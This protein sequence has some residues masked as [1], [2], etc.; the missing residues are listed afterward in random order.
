MLNRI[1]NAVL[2]SGLS[3]KFPV[4]ADFDTRANALI[5]AFNKALKGKVSGKSLENVI[6]ASGIDESYAEELFD[7]AI[8]PPLKQLIEH[9]VM[10]LAITGGTAVMGNF[11]P[12]EIENT[13]AYMKNI[14]NL[15]GAGILDH[16]FVDQLPLDRVKT[17]Y[18]R[19]I[20][21]AKLQRS[22]LLDTGCSKL[23]KPEKVSHLVTDVNNNFYTTNTFDDDGLKSLYVAMVITDILRVTSE[24]PDEFSNCA[25][26]MLTLFE[27]EQ[28]QAL[29]EVLSMV[30]T[31]NIDKFESAH[32]SQ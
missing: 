17:V 28:E 19:C 26:R 22:N 15:I 8:N 16:S 21:D 12:Y 14:N 24:S 23:S 20:I 1:V 10:R 5:S 2:H 30:S 18:G 9:S 29:Q 31:E 7:F 13:K 25:H 4:N 3:R 32:V 27:T 11:V 6:K